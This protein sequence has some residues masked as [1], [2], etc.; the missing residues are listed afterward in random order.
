MRYPCATPV[1]FAVALA[2]FF[3][4]PASPGEAK[5]L[6]RNPP[7]SPEVVLTIDPGKVVLNNGHS[8][9]QLAALRDRNAPAS[10][11]DRR[12]SPVGL[13]LTERQFTMRVQVRARRAAKG[14]FCGDLTKVAARIGYDKLNVYVARKYR[15]GS[16]HY[17]SVLDHENKHVAVFR[18]TLVKYAP[19]IERRIRRLASR[20]APVAARSAD[21]TAKI[22]QDK[23]QR[24][25]KPLFREMDR[26]IDFRNGKLDTP[27]NYRQEQ[28]RC[29]GW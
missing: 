5:V 21:Q 26:E 15:P 10:T 29:S 3:G 23:L 28:A 1:L 4:A 11:F 27:Q 20:M 18:N 8:R 22:F 14:R 13:T 9:R 19:R 7:G 25:L 6:C 12:W 17:R 16:C 24:N 2:G